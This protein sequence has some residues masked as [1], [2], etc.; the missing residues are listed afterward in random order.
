MVTFKKKF[1]ITTAIAYPNSVPHL[2]HALEIVQADVVARFHKLLGKDVFFQTGTDEHGTKNWQAAKKEGKDV[3][4]FLDA[5][6]A[7]FKDLYKKLN[8]SYDQFIRTIDKKTHWPGVIKLWKELVKSGDIYK[9]NY[10]GL[11]CTGCEEFKIER[12]LQNNKCH[13]HHTREIET[14]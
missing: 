12:E 9:K 8:I 3:K 4:K 5:N 11:Y 7:I 10:K 6:V 1:Y 2:G 14:V 13:N